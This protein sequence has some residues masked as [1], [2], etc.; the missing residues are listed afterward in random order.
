MSWFDP[1]KLTGTIGN[2][3][4]KV[5]SLAEQ[6][7]EDDYVAIEKLKFQLQQ[8]Q[9]E[10]DELLMQLQNQSRDPSAAAQDDISQ[11]RQQMATMQQQH[12]NREQELTGTLNNLKQRA[13][14][15]IKQ[16]MAKNQEL[17]SST[18]TGKNPD[19]EQ[20]L[21]EKEEELRA[22][23]RQWEMR[24]AE[25]EQQWVQE[26]EFL[27]AEIE[28]IQIESARLVQEKE[29]ELQSL[30]KAPENQ[31]GM[32]DAIQRERDTLLKG[33]EELRIDNSRLQ[34]AITDLEAT[35]SEAPNDSKTLSI[36]PKKSER[37]V[38]ATEVLEAKLQEALQ[39]I[40]ERDVQIELLK[41][42]LDSS[43]LQSRDNGNMQQ[44]AN[45]DLQKLETQLN[46]AHIALEERDIYIQQIQ[47]ELEQVH[48]QLEEQ[49]DRTSSMDQVCEENIILRTQV[50]ELTQK[51]QEQVAEIE[52]LA[53]PIHNT[54]P[55]PDS[56]QEHWEIERASLIEV[57]K[58]LEQE[59]QTLTQ[60]YQ[61]LQDQFFNY[62]EAS[63]LENQKSNLKLKDLQQKIVDLEH[64][65]HVALEKESSVVRE[66]QQQLEDALSVHNQKLEAEFMAKESEWKLNKKSL[67]TQIHSL[68]NKQ[69]EL[70]ATIEADKKELAELKQ[71]QLPSKEED[72]E[73]RNADLQA[74]IG[75]LEEEIRQLKLSQAEESN[76]QGIEY[77]S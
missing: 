13:A 68:Q 65:A 64:D 31:Y 40:E 29:R 72:L 32:L 38:S 63:K 42:E 26:R 6:L 39:T 49:R 3:A 35:R 5:Q 61:L 45:F 59:L 18:D 46:D 58:R 37:E 36:D 51:I 22:T 52:R 75:T 57:Q 41:S 73:G 25:L 56:S 34:E 74:T 30:K 12:Q 53:S 17:L 8:T 20:K 28:Q 71:N 44:D 1:N 33:I 19:L 24:C 50:D 16:L 21:R 54:S 66:L 4:N 48:A 9:K 27:G 77:L 62:E 23:N 2:I 7:Q 60:E 11:L 67:D 76:L 55:S 15:K 70:L 47:G 43:T 10:R 14:E 69:E